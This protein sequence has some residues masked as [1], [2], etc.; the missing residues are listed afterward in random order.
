MIN[1][2]NCVTKIVVI[3]HA[4][5]FKC[6]NTFQVSAFLRLSLPTNFRKVPAL[7]QSEHSQL[8]REEPFPCAVLILIPRLDDFSEFLQTIRADT[9]LILTTYTIPTIIA[10]ILDCMLHDKTN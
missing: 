7:Q 4:I 8:Q 6:S 5:K 3:E 10:T 9:S 2:C 1:F